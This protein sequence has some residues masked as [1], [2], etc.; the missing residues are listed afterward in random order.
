MKMFLL[1]LAFCI[2]VVVAPFVIE[3]H[4][5]VYI[6][7]G[8]YSIETSFVLAVG[9]VILAVAAVLF[10]FGLAKRLFRAHKSVGSFFYRRR[11]AKAGSNFYSGIIALLEG[12]DAE[13][14]RRL[15]T[16][17][18]NKHRTVPGYLL[19]ARAAAKMKKE[20][21]CAKCL[22]KARAADARSELACALIEADLREAAGEDESAIAVLQ[23]V[24][25]SDQENAVVLRRLA[26][27]FLKNADHERLE[28]ILPVVKARRVLPYD[29]FLRVQ[30]ASYERRLNE[31][32]DPAEAMKL[33]DTVSRNFRREPS[34]S[35]AFARRLASLGDIKNAETIVLEGLRKCDE[36][37]MALE[38]ANIETSLPS[39][40]KKLQTLSEAK[41]NIDLERALG[42]QYMAA[43]DYPSAIEKF[44][45][46]VSDRPANEDLVRLSRCYEAERLFEKASVTLKQAMS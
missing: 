5:Y 34:V 10:L 28:A 20:E 44:R 41:N 16:D 1:C 46:V 42:C 36:S 22:A 23:K 30:V 3:N 17:T 29:E 15:V 12:D 33:W 14:Y 6:S 38:I 37:G 24:L 32:T 27:I 8:G 35:C 45:L 25:E 31:M 39:V 19:A 26:G 11:A 7:I 4:G 21:D 2:A 40:L 43:G 18:H 13:A 9:L